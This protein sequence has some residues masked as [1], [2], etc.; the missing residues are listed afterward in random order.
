MKFSNLSTLLAII[1]CGSR[2]SN[3][4]FLRLP[5]KRL[6]STK[7]PVHRGRSLIESNTD[8]TCLG[9]TLEGNEMLN[10]NEAVCDTMYDAFGLDKGGNIVWLRADVD[11][12]SVTTF[13]RADNSPADY[14][15]MQGD[16]NLVARAISSTGTDIVWN[17][18]T[19]G[20]QNSALAARCWFDPVSLSRGNF[21]KV[22]IAGDDQYWESFA[23]NDVCRGDTLAV[24]GILFV[25]D[26]LCAAEYRL[27]MSP[28]G[29][30]QLQH[31]SSWDDDEW[32]TVWEADQDGNA[33]TRAVLQADGNFVVRDDAG[34]ALWASNTDG[35]P[36]SKV[37]L[38]NSGGT[39]LASEDSS[40]LWTVNYDPDWLCV[41][42]SLTPNTELR[43]NE[44]LC[45]G[46]K[47][48]GLVGGTLLSEEFYPFTKSWQKDSKANL[49]T[50]GSGGKVVM[51]WN[52]NLVIYSDNVG[53]LWST[54]TNGHP[55]TVLGFHRT[56]PGSYT[57]SNTASLKFE[58]TIIYL[59]EEDA[60]ESKCVGEELS[61]GGRMDSGEVLCSSNGIPTFGMDATGD[62]ALWDKYDRSEKI[63]S[64]GTGGSYGNSVWME[65]NGDLAVY[66]Y[67]NI[68]LWHSET[69]GNSGATLQ[70]DPDGNVAVVSQSDEDVLWSLNEAPVLPAHT[71]VSYV[72][73]GQRLERNQMIC[74]VNNQDSFGLDADG[75][76][77]YNSL[78]GYPF[79]SPAYWTGG[80]YDMGGRFGDYATFQGDGDFVVYS[81]DDEALW[82]TRTNVGYPAEELTYACYSQSVCSLKFSSSTE[83][84]EWIQEDY[85]CRGQYLYAGDILGAEEFICSEKN[86]HRFGVDKR[87]DLGLWLR[88]RNTI[89][90][91]T[92]DDYGS[93]GNHLSMQSDGNLVLYSYN[94][95]PLWD[96]DSQNNPS[97]NNQG[98]YIFIDDSG[99]VAVFASDGTPLFNIAS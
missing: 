46:G 67:D 35:N 89:T 73:P 40:V 77:T 27:G 84:K 26:F 96:L 85:Y 59:S 58:D 69:A 3:A 14:L 45:K 56:G 39:Q 57:Y 74:T 75:R 5:E 61:S 13:W 90:M 15:K 81:R 72:V 8:M 11:T 20:D 48:I 24:D 33:G 83:A 78:L 6:S 54:Q 92:S 97:K 12:G 98:A 18:R 88:G 55:N 30:L 9:D 37:T 63:W 93:Y 32:E 42:D 7:T 16:G 1:L 95:S 36:D 44:Y 79:V 17:S 76:M 25:G 65:I 49:P 22:L 31:L 51:R 19:P 10:R 71:C 34:R 23:S 62:L 38:F 41:G 64:A 99:S 43:K 28:S 68:M 82:S 4:E 47:T 21:C 53:P 66:S 80:F 70:F 60:V 86:G 87:G 91:G 50:G 52:G 2:C 94:S 29:T